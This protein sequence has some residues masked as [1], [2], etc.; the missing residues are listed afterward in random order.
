M[1]NVIMLALSLRKNVKEI[2]IGPLRDG[3]TTLHYIIFSYKQFFK[4]LHNFIFRYHIPRSW[5]KPT[6]NV[7]VVFE[8]FGGD[9]T[10]ISLVKRTA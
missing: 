1:V 5:L 8:E 9:P 2:A 3:K 7:L 10:K 4:N 6:G